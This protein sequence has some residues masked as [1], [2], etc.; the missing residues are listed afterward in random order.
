MT[1]VFPIR[2]GDLVGGKYRVDRKL[3][4]GGMGVVFAATQLV[5]ERP[6]A[7]K[8]LLPEVLARPGL[9]TR[10][11]RE[12]RAAAQLQSEHV[13]RVLDVGTLESGAPYIVMEYLEG[14]DFASIIAARGALPPDEA[15]GY[16]LQSCEAVAEAHALG[17]VHRDLK[18]GNLF[19]ANRTSGPPVVKVLDFGLSKFADRN[20]ENVTSESSIL[21]SPLYMS[22]E[23]LMSASTADARS[24]LWSL[25]VVLYELLTAH[26]PFQYE[27]IA[28]LVTAILQK[29][30]VPMDQWREGIPLALQAVVATCLEK[31]PALRCP[32]VAHF[33]R[34]LAPF[35]PPAAARSVERVTHLLR[36]SAP[37]VGSDAPDP[38]PAADRES[39]TLHAL[40][41]LV[42]SVGGSSHTIREGQLDGT[43][44]SLPPSTIP[45]VRRWTWAG[46]AGLGGACALAIAGALAASRP[47]SHTDRDVTSPSVAAARVDGASLLP[48]E[49]RPTAP[50][51]ADVSAAMAPVPVTTPA[52]STKPV[53]PPRSPP[54]APPAPPP[55]ASA[56]PVP[57]SPTPDDPLRRLKTM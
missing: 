9:I 54:A 53:R 25:G 39:P 24:D 11:S 12:A 4:A 23:Q 8:F 33:A 44:P 28:G 46:V 37:S 47:T 5:L 35:G 57:N 21:G 38:A 7:L 36:T 2:P 40:A 1:E 34:A 16:L 15:V 27:R 17:I 52:A 50:P 26:A 3:G 31:D 41:P 6:V 13:A 45:R 20:E 56:A 51:T 32:T 42:E 30:P 55:S 43:L 10:F 19:L 22:P 49:P 14:A 29:P 18:P 48:A